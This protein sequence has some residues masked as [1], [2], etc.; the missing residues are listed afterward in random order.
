M[1]SY[2]PLLHFNT[3]LFHSSVSL[4]NF[5]NTL[6]TLNCTLT[7]IKILFPIPTYPSKLTMQ[8]Y[9]IS[10]IPLSYLFLSPIYSLRSRLFPSYPSTPLPNPQYNSLVYSLPIPLLPFLTPSIILL[11]PTLKIRSWDNTYYSKLKV[12]HKIKGILYTLLY[13]VSCP[14]NTRNCPINSRIVL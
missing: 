9:N 10:L 14:I 5:Y 3:P 13:E 6:S 7:I 11:F 12:K 4:S 2:T 8:L 1:H